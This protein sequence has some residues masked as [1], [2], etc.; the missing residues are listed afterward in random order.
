MP[1]E[2]SDKKPPQ[3]PT[4]GNLSTKITKELDQIT[5]SDSYRLAVYGVPPFP[6]PEIEP[7]PLIVRWMRRISR[8]PYPV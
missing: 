8:R 3:L 2:K 5:S 4:A 7:D 1:D 6:L